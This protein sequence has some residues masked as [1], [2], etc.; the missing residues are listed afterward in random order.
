MKAYFVKAAEKKQQRHIRASQRITDSA[1]PSES[2]TPPESREEDDQ[3]SHPCGD[4]FV[5][6]AQDLRISAG[7]M[8]EVLIEGV[9]EVEKDWFV[10]RILI[11][12]S[13]DDESFMGAP[14][15]M[16]RGGKGVKLPV[17]NTSSRP[18]LIHK[19]ERL[20][21]LHD[22]DRYLDREEAD[23]SGTRNREAIALAVKKLALSGPARGR[24]LIGTPMRSTA[25]EPSALE[26]PEAKEESWGPKISE[27]GDPSTID[28]KDFESAFD[29][30]SDMPAEI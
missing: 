16:V 7:H 13:K 27:P 21:I 26:D 18:R 3:T 29:I 25:R 10:E 8:A 15:T 22:P 1:N 12:N 19:G 28:S 23:D 2:L 17:V 9:P 20:G 30:S 11:V 5:T 24:E 6:V 4:S 14:S